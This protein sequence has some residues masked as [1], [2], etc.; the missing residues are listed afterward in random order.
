MYT[1]RQKKYIR[2]E[3]TILEA[4]LSPHPSNYYHLNHYHNHHSIIVCG[5]DCG[6]RVASRYGLLLGL[7]SM[8]V[9]DLMPV[10]IIYQLPGVVTVMMAVVALMVAGCAASWFCT[11]GSRLR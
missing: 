3:H 8:L 11:D 4:G 1:I 5:G 2:T 9:F 10:S 7:R 6:G